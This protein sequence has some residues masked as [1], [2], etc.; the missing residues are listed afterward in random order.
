M[1]ATDRSRMLRELFRIFPDFELCRTSVDNVACGVTTYGKARELM[2]KKA[3]GAK[4]NH[5]EIR[6]RLD[7]KRIHDGAGWRTLKDLS[8]REIAALPDSPLTEVLQFYLKHPFAHGRT[9]SSRIIPRLIR[10]LFL[11][12][13]I[14]QAMRRRLKLDAA[15]AMELLELL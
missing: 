6:D 4:L 8:W 9:R 7:S 5:R 11:R 13:L 2:W 10:T 1:D 3:E 15:A 14:G 12:Q